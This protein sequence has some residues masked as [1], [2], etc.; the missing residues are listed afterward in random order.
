MAIKAASVDAW[1]VAGWRSA[2]AAVVVFAVLPRA[3]RGISWSVVPVGVTYALTLVFFTLGA[4]RTT[5]ANAIFLQYLAP[6]WIGLLGPWLLG[7]SMRRRDVP[8]LA[9]MGA[10]MACIFFGAPGPQQSAPEPLVGNLYGMASGLTLAFTLIGLRALGLRAT[11]RADPGTAAV[12]VGNAIAWLS[13]LP[14][15]GDPRQIGTTDWLWLVYLGAVQIGLAYALLTRA[16]PVVPA[17]ELSL[18]LLVEPVLN[19]VWAGIVQREDP[20]LMAV[21]GGAIVI[22]TLAL[23]SLRDRDAAGPPP[24]PDAGP[25]S[26]PS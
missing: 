11:D 18:I 5:A 17:F 14:F 2:V 19:P 15:L 4:K 24:R 23:R 20:G 12:I 10:G 26:P 9:A 16:T 1:T 7:E 25:A 3:R 8:Y 6:L 13:C 21:L 22:G